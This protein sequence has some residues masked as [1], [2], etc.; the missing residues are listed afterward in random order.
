[1]D[2]ERKDAA[3]SPLRVVPRQRAPRGS[4]KGPA[5]GEILVE[6]KTLTEEQL[7]E[8]MTRQQRSRKRLGEILM[9][10]GFAS[11][12]AVLD[13]LSAQ[14]GV[15][16][17][18]VNSYTVTPEALTCLSEKV[19]R[20]YTAVPLL[21]VGSTLIVATANP[22][23]LQAL[24]DLRFAAGCEVQTMIALESE[25]LQALATFYGNPFANDA[26]AERASVVV[27]VPGPQLD[28]QDQGTQKSASSI[29]DRILA[30]GAGDRAS[31][32]HLEPTKHSLRVRFRIDGMLHEVA[33]LLPVLAPAVVARL[34]VLAGMDISVHRNPQDGR[35]SATINGR[36][37]DMRT[38]TFPT[39]WGE[40]A[41]LRLLDRSSAAALGIERHERPLARGVPRSDSRHEGIVLVT[42]PTGSG[43]T[44]T[45]Y[46]AL[47]ELAESGRNVVTIED[48]VEYWLPGVSQ[49]QTNPK[50]GFTFAQ[51]LRA[52]LRQDPDVIM[53]GE[54]RDP[55]TLADRHRSVAHWPPRAFHAAHQRIRRDADAAAR[56]GRRAVSARVVHGRRRRAAAGS[57]DLRV[58]QE[59]GRRRR[60]R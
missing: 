25:I 53:V 41:V 11:P 14:L 33:E 26:E 46:A 54:I 20:K 15:P 1:M 9:E 7:R 38:S 19:A 6:R 35:F 31:D 17:T 52:I 34:K 16:P 13:G 30:R 12:D 18:R 37:L 4:K 22:R 23:D 44:S 32:I 8:A 47:A 48:P 36:S 40:K 21:K 3:A 51:G 42:G 45:L 27:D 10:L 55:E 39:I 43:K 59:A 2:H 57:Q 58:V 56:Y 49:G 5:L 28:L 60:T 29:V 24:D 50:A